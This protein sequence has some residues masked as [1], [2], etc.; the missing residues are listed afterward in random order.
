MTATVMFKRLLSVF[1][2]ITPEDSRKRA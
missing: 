1:A 2:E